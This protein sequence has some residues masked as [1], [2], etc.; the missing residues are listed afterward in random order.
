RHGASTVS[1]QEL[2]KDRNNRRHWIH[3]KCAQDFVARTP[4]K[5]VTYV[6]PPYHFYS[7]GGAGGLGIPEELRR[8]IQEAG[9]VWNY[10]WQRLFKVACLPCPH[11]RDPVPVSRY[12]DPRKHVCDEKYLLKAKQAAKTRTR[13]NARTD[14]T[15]W[16]ATAFFRE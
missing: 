11:C 5:K 10:Y 3:V 12:T 6:R 2:K 7:G 14:R 16:L 15:L 13:G 9:G 1:E 4:N 8:A